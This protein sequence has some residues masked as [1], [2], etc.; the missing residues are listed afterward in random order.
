[1]EAEPSILKQDGKKQSENS[2]G[3]ANKTN[4]EK[5]SW[6]EKWRGKW[7]GMPPD[8]KLMACFTGV[9]ALCTLVYAFVSYFQLRALLDSNTINRE[10]VQAVQ[11]AFVRWDS[12]SIRPHVRSGPKGEEQYLDVLTNWENSGA[13][14]ATEAIDYY[15]VDELPGEPDGEIFWGD[16]GSPHNTNYLGPKGRLSHSIKRPLSFYTG[17]RELGAITSTRELERKIFFWGWI[18]Y[19]DVFPKTKPH[20]TEFCHQMVLIGHGITPGQ[21]TS[22][23]PPR[24]PDLSLQTQTCQEHNCVDQDC[25][26]YTEIMK[27]TE[28]PN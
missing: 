4:R 20:L 10:S 19:R 15:R 14:P 25:T 1:M 18:V 23:P 13:T 11:R 2:N 5:G 7:R 28:P 27:L 26:D 24:W 22:F 9:I 17:A 3:H 8:N 21:K 12:F 6:Y 16:K